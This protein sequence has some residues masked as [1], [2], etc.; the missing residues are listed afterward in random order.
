MSY[1]DNEYESSGFD[2]INLIK[3]DSIH[4]KRKDNPSKPNN[5]KVSVW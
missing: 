1:K 4:D 5:A 2:P 3:Q